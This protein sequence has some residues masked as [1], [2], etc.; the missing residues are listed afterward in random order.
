MATLLKD[1]GRLGED[2]IR[3]L[4]DPDRGI[5][6]GRVFTDPDVYQLELERIFLKSWCFLGHESQIRNPGDFFASAIG[7]DR[8]VASVLAPR[9]DT[10]MPQ[11][12]QCCIGTHGLAL[13]QRNRCIARS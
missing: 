6:S 9:P 13:E 8:R 7:E 12:A 10:R 11:R 5:V 3:R 1:S 4:V 2:E